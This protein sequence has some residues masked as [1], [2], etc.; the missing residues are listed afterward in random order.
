MRSPKTS[1]LRLVSIEIYSAMFRLKSENVV[2]VAASSIYHLQVLA[3][4]K[5][6]LYTPTLLASLPVTV[7][8][9]PSSLRM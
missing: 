1:Y 4:L 7:M 3:L 6:L 5:Q 2:E 8:A 9:D